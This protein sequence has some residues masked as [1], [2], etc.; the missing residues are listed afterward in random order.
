M[1]YGN[2]RSLENIVYWCDY[3]QKFKREIFKD[4]FDYEGLYQISNLGRVKSLKCNR[5]KILKLSFDTGGYSQV[6]LCENSIKKTRDVHKL[7]AIHFLN[8]TPCGFKL[9]VNHKDFNKLN[10]HVNNLEI[11]TNRVNCNKKHLKSTSKYTGVYWHKRKN[12]WASSIMINGK[13]K[14]LGLFINEEEASD[15][16]QNKLKE[17]TI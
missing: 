11:V 7:V 12:K 17:I 8:H 14:Y 15:V 6:G 5:E 2:V 4:I 9:V 10:N 16:Y 13:L 3:S 1:E